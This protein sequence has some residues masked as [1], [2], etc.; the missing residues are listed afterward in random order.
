[1]TSATDFTRVVAVAHDLR[2]SQTIAN[3]NQW[4][5]AKSNNW[6]SPIDEKIQYW[7]IEG[8]V[9]GYLRSEGAVELKEQAGWI[10]MQRYQ[11]QRKGRYDIVSAER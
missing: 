3:Q 9:G 4:L 6:K 7:N 10:E 5:V 2:S 11:E 8:R 1:M